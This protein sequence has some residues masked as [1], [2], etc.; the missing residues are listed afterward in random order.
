MLKK[1]ILFNLCFLS[2]IFLSFLQGA[3]PPKVRKIVFIGISNRD[4]MELMD[5]IR[6]SIN[7]PFSDYLLSEDIRSLYKLRR[8]AYVRS[9]V[10]SYEDGVKVEFILKENPRLEKVI[11]SGRKSIELSKIVKAIY[12][13]K[14]NYYHPAFV[15]QDIAAIL[16]LY[17]EEGFYLAEIR[18]RVRR[19]SSKAVELVLLI[20]EGPKVQIYHVHLV[21]NQKFSESQILPYIK[22][23]YRYSYVH[24]P[25]YFRPFSYLAFLLFSWFQDF[26]YVESKIQQDMEI[27]RLFYRSKGYFDVQV[28][29]EDLRFDYYKETVDVV[30]RVREGKQYNVG[31][32]LFHLK[33]N[34]KLGKYQDSKSKEKYFRSLLTL[35]EGMPFSGEKLQNDLKS[36]QKVYRRYAYVLAKVNIDLKFYKDKNQVDLLFQIQEKE[37]VRLGKIRIE[38]NTR[39]RDS[40]IRRY[41]TFF[42]GEWFNGDKVDESRY[43]INNLR[44]FEKLDFELEPGTVKGTQDMIIKVKEGRTGSFIIGGA[45]ASDFGF[46]GNFQFLQRNFDITD[47][48]KSWSDF[49]SGNAFVGGGQTLSISLQPGIDRSNY[50]ILFR[51]PFLFGTPIIFSINGFFFNRDQLDYVEERLGGSITFGYRLTPD[52]TIETTLEHQRIN[53]FDLPLNPPQDLLDVKGNSTLN[54]LTFAVTFN[55]L[56][57]DRYF[58]SYGGY[59]ITGSY[60][61][62]GNFL[63]GSY[64][65]SKALGEGRIYFWLFGDEDWKNIL[66]LRASAGWAEPNGSSKSIPIFQRFFLG[67]VRSMRGFEYRGIGPII[68]S[69]RLGGNLMLFGSAEFQFPLLSTFLRG[70]LFLDAGKL[71]QDIHD[72]RKADFKL[73]YGFGFA[74]RIPLFPAPVRLFFGFPF[75]K[76]STD[77]RQTFHFDLGFNF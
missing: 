75:K 35:K 17:H 44:Y 40:V 16:K 20:R 76:T 19:I 53:I 57:V 59:R 54:T 23:S 27:I 29:L 71:A 43:K 58:T 64:H 60:E 28:M 2:Y 41:L 55:K 52:L 70:V 50:N 14:G 7:E 12:S 3:E 10:S 68:N 30:F 24:S 48:P 72:L 18:Y 36:I 34:A 77:E 61:Y 45:I 26:P 31:K 39:T 8:F 73:S 15:N 65:Y 47:F 37:K 56:K 42:P 67:G 13:K 49:I 62:A 22:S 46:F 66:M 63:Q 1:Q 21:G 11:L 69:V 33:G 32:F 9:K 5:K 6:L 38:G 51:E 4:T 25:W 74:I